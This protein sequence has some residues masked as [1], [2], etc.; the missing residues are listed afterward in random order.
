MFGKR[1]KGTSRA[2]RATTVIPMFVSTLAFACVA[3]AGPD[4]DL[5]LEQDA[6]STLQGAQKITIPSQVQTVRGA[7]TGLA[8]QGGGDFQDVYLFQITDPTVFSVDSTGENGATFDICMWLFSF[9]GK[10]LLGNNDAFE[11]TTGAKIGNAS[12]DGPNVLITEPGF[13]YL[14]IT[15]FASQPT[16]FNG[17]FLF[18]QSVFTPG[19]VS[20]G[21]D[22]RFGGLWSGDGATGSYA[23][24]TEGIAGIPG[25]GAIALLGLAGLRAGRRRTA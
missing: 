1:E 2:M 10:P 4:W 20:G 12:N 15:G 23:I 5:D 13:Y 22:G 25:P 6:G 14:A 21:L 9:E 16:G 18:P 17:E 24:K 11:G 7:L 8:F 19:N 3:A